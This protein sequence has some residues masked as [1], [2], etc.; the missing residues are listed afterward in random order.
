MNCKVNYAV[1]VKEN[2]PDICSGYNTQGWLEETNNTCNILI[3]IGN[4]KYWYLR[5]MVYS[6][7]NPLTMR[8]KYNYIHYGQN[9]KN[10]PQIK[11]APKPGKPQPSSRKGQRSVICHLGLFRSPRLGPGEV[12]DGAQ[13]GGG[14]S[15]GQP[16]C[17]G[18]RLFASFFL[19]S[20]GSAQARWPGS[21][22]SRKAGSPAVAQTQ[23]RSDGIYKATSFR[24]LILTLRRSCATHAGSLWA[25]GPFPQHRASL[26]STGKKTS[27]ATPNPPEDLADSSATAYEEI[28]SQVLGAPQRYEDFGLVLLLREGVAAW[29][30]HCKIRPA[31]TE[32]ESLADQAVSPP[33]LLPQLHADIVRLLANMVLSGREEMRL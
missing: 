16:Q 9:Q 8:H 5:I 19:S 22:R 6:G 17:D 25:Q 28:R 14:P 13:S 20:P 33:V 2:M 27:L 31:P 10:R 32:Q 1:T 30:D 11:S 29:I 12:R 23:Q 3:I 18:L 21:S 4:A 24:R 15:T 26:G 7:R